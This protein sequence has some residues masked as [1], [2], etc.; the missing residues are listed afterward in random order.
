ME[1]SAGV[2]GYK[3]HVMSE[4]DFCVV[5]QRSGRSVRKNLEDALEHSRPL[6][7]NPRAGFSLFTES[8]NGRVWK[9]PL[10]VI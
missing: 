3:R 4:M 6:L 9:G 10:W 2:T 5:L 7:V 8:Q 1:S